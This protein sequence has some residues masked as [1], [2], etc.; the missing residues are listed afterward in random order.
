ME[1][2]LH[3]F[4]TWAVD[5]AEWSASRRPLYPQGKSPWYVF[6]RRL[7]GLQRWSERSGEEKESL[8]CACRGIEH[9]SS[10]LYWL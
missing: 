10:S 5:G 3:A 9:R 2:W 6:D 7:D 4:L 8:Y 1:V